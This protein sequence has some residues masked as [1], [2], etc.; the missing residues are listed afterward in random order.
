M[1]EPAWTPVPDP[2]PTPTPVP[3]P[4][5]EPEPGPTPTPVPTR[6]DRALALLRIAVGALF[7]IFGEYKIADSR[8]V[9]QGF[10]YWI[11]RF[12]Q[13]GAYP[14]L[15]PI[16]KGPV[17]GHE[18]GWAWLVAIGELA[19]GAAL[20]LGICVRAASAGGLVFM[21]ALLFSANY[22]GPSAPL[23]Q[24][25]GAALDHLTLAFCFAAFVI[26][27]ADAAYRIRLPWRARSGSMSGPA[28]RG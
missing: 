21:L 22:P 2:A 19:I 18:H 24:Y 8:F 16:L 11:E 12:L 23:W 26:G 27:R 7:L 4:T 17:L 14:F 25:F 13:G 9:D 10:R 3:A 5:P 28:G 6:N 15:V 20:T 1:P